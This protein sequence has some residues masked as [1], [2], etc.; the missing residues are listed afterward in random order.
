M[1]IVLAACALAGLL[2]GCAGSNPALP[3]AS[4]LSSA[5]AA[6]WRGQGENIA[7]Y[8]LGSNEHIYTRIP[9]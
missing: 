5:H 3:G 4:A 9:F 6:S 2:G 7:H 1:K 8:R